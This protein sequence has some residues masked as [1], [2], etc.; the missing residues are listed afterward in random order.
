[1]SPDGPVIPCQRQI[2]T[3]GWLD[4]F[5]ITTF[6]ITPEPSTTTT[7]AT[8]DD[9]DWNGDRSST[10]NSGSVVIS[11]DDTNAPVIVTGGSV[12]A[13]NDV[14]SFAVLK[15]FPRRLEQFKKFAHDIFFCRLRNHANHDDSTSK[16][17]P[18]RERPPRV[19]SFFDW[20]T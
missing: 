19:R 3:N 14:I 6:T 9:N 18:S 2:A 15:E 8:D 20:K 5:V 10:T 16:C 4:G 7:N 13:E 1:M 11:D 17:W 12:G